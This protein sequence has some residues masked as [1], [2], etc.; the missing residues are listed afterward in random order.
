MLPSVGLQNLEKFFKPKKVICIENNIYDVTAFLSE[1]PGGSEIL[2]QVMFTDA[3]QV[4][5]AMGHSSTARR[6]LK[7]LHVGYLVK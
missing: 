1:H 3:T 5:N 4:F 6:E 7:K 2:E